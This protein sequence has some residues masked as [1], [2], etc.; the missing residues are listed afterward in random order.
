M[1]ALISINRA[2]KQARISC[3]RPVENVRRQ[4]LKSYEIAYT[5]FAA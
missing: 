3:S 4:L 1:T 2:Q 5:V